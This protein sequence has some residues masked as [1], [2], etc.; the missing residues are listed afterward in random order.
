MTMLKKNFFS[1]AEAYAAPVC[2]SL[3][4]TV[5]EGIMVLSNGDPGQAGSNPGIGSEDNNYGPF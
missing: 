5:N 1:A 4:F 3:D 2:E